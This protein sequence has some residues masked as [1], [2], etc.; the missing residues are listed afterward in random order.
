[1]AENANSQAKIY[2]CLERTLA[3]VKEIFG[4][5]G[6]LNIVKLEVSGIRCA[7]M[8]LEAMVSS[9]DLSKMLFSPLM[10]YNKRHAEPQDVFDFLSKQGIFS[11]EAKEIKTLSDI[12]ERLCSGF[13]IVLVNGVSKGMAY[14]AQ[15]FE[16]RS[17]SESDSESNV[18][19]TR[20]SLSDNLRTSMSLIRRRAKSPLLRFEFVK[21]GKISNTELC[22]VYIE[23]KTPE[24]LRKLIKSRLKSIRLD[25]ILTSGNVL[26][27]ISENTGAFFSEVSTTERPDVLV[28]KINEGRIAILIDG[29]PHAAICPS[30]F[31]E[32]FQVVDDYEEKPYFVCYQRWIRYISFFIASFL[33]GLYVAAAIHHPEVLSRAL[34]LNLI[35]SEEN[36]PFPLVAEMFIVIIM[37][38]ILREAGLRLPKAVGGAVS[39]VGGLVIGD[40]A[41]TSGLISAPLLI[42]I[43]ITATSSFALPSL[44]AQTTLL[45]LIGVAVGGAFGFFGI[46]VFMTLSLV[47]AAATDCFAV[48]YTSPVTPFTLKAMRDVITRIGFKKM[49]DQS[50]IVEDLNGAGGDDLISD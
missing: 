39:I 10:D 20:E 38:E 8:T 42:I 32:N 41:V 48:P 43:G 50:V 21:A 33:P 1:M 2:S 29:V 46:G 19:G 22:L 17:V 45:R 49:Q 47:N 3:A 27:F 13:A 4:E 11:V 26:P 23:G 6:D 12:S 28:A 24:K 15:G 30:L 25:L 34:L 18:K 7:V 5:S 37:F 31:I 14:S 40:A 9:S 44:N 36:T 35:A 16:V